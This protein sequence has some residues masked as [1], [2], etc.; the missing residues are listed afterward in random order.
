MLPVMG[1]GAADD[2]KLRPKQSFSHDGMVSDANS[3]SERC[4]KP[5][6]Q[7]F[8]YSSSGELSLR[9]QGQLRCENTAL[10]SHKA[11]VTL[12]SYL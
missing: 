12:N 4:G 3:R 6:P 9:A 7:A 8:I 1:V 5:Q 10:D 11:D 2:P